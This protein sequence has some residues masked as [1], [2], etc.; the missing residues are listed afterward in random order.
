MERP[1]SYEDDQ[2]IPDHALPRFRGNPKDNYQ[3]MSPA[4]ENLCGYWT[5]AHQSPH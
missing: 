4:P 2:A 3:V 1:V 5:K